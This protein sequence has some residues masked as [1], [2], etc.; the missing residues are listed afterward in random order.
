M[1]GKPLA[2]VIV[3]FHPAVGA[4]E[5][6]GVTTDK[7]EYFLRY[8][9]DDLGTAVGTNSVRI[10]KQQNNDPSSETVP[11]KYN[12]QTT[13]KREIKPGDNEINFELTSK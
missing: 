6:M 12:R 2:R 4:R 9:R 13:L 8:I 10:T 5:A 1:D 7:G 11:A 3:I